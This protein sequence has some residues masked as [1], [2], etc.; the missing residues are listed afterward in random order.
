MHRVVGDSYSL[1]FQASSI[2]HGPTPALKKVGTELT[3]FQNIKSPSINSEANPPGRGK[4]TWHTTD[5]T[6][7]AEPEFQFNL[8]TLQVAP[9][10][11]LSLARQTGIR[12]R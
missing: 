3:T 9:G 10:K 5:P 11:V 2:G 1:F 6:S 8:S 7:Q 4:A 12:M